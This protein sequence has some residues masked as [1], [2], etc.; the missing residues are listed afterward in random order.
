MFSKSYSTI[1]KFGAGKISLFFK[2]SLMFANCIY[3]IK[4]KE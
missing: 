4:N 1:Q 3:L 2:K